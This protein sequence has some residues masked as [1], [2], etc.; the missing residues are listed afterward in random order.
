MGNTAKIRHR[1]RRRR[2]RTRHAFIAGWQQAGKLLV[3]VEG[4]RRLTPEE[5]RA[6]YG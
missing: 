4:P 1:R 3:R 6:A 5:V 2:E